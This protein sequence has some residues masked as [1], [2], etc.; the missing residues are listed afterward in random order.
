MAAGANA[1]GASPVVC[2]RRKSIGSAFAAVGEE[3]NEICGIIVHS[4]GSPQSE[5]SGPDQ[6]NFGPYVCR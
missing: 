5:P 2:A 6:G 1:F 3:A 4:A